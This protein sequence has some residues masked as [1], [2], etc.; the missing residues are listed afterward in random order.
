M[1]SFIEITELVKSSLS[2]Y[3]N[4]LPATHLW[5][6]NR[7]TQSGKPLRSEV[8]KSKGI[9][10]LADIMVPMIGNYFPIMGK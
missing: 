7:L 9:E 6:N 2:F 10:R 4:T 3:N 8:W 5:D 1:T